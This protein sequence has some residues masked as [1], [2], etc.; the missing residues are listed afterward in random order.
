MNKTISAGNLVDDPKI[1]YTQGGKAK[2][3]FTLA[4]QRMKEGAD[5]PRFIAWEKKAEVLEKYCHKGDKL[6]VEGKI[7]TDSYENKEGKKVY[8]TDIIV[9][10]IEFCTRKAKDETVGQPKENPTDEWMKIP[11]GV[12]EELPFK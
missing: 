9:D 12:Q 2:A 3:E 4:L 11:E 1:S 10:N 7:H 5:F 8:T 6:I